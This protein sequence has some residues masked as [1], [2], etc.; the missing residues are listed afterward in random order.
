VAMLKRRSS[1]GCV[2]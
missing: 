1:T 2:Y